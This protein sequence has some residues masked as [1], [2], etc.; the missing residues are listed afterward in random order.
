MTGI[1]W[2]STFTLLTEALV[3]ASVLY[4]LYSGYY[5]NRFP[6]KLVVVTLAYETLFNISYMSYRA[7][8]HAD[9]SA[10]P[11]S[12]FHI[13]I[14]I[15]HGTFSLLMFIALIIFMYYAWKN[16]RQG[17]NFFQ[18]F[19]KLTLIF[20]IAWLIAVFSGVFFYY[21]AYFSTEEIQTRQTQSK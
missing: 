19:K 14:A 13:A 18:K 12:S 3:T 9:D 15:F 20:L 21:E 17:I 5:K 1:P 2:F 11:D 10:H 6:S 7:L 4:I 8:S 16:Y